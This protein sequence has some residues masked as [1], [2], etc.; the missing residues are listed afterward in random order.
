MRSTLALRRH[1]RLRS[2]PLFTSFSP[3]RCPDG[4]KCAH[5]D[6]TNLGTIETEAGFYRFTNTS[7]QTYP[8]PMGATCLGGVRSG[9][10][11]CAEGAEGPL[12][13]VW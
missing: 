13:A 10:A 5:E 6:G 3:V 4:A 7:R 8:C 1:T 12:C 2:A 11:L 9:G